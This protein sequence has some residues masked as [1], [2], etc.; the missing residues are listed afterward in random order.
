MEV[1]ERE[2]TPRQSFSAIVGPNGSGKSNTIDALLFVFGFKANKM[3][4]GHVSEL[5]HVSEGKEPTSCSVEIHF[6]DIVDLVRR[7]AHCASLT[8]QPGPDAYDI[9]PDSTLIVSRTAYKN[10]SSTYKINNRTATMK[11]VTTLLKGRGIDL[12]HKRF[13]ILQGE[14]E[15]IAQMKPKAPNEHEDGL[16][17]YLEDIIGTTRLVAPIGEAGKA[18]EALV[19]ERS[20]KFARLKIV[21]REKLALEP[22]KA[23]A[24]AWIRDTNDAVLRNSELWQLNRHNHNRTL[25]NAQAE[26]A[27]AQAQLAQETQEQAETRAQVAEAQTAVKETM[28]EVKVREVSPIRSPDR[29]QNIELAASKVIKILTDFETKEATLQEREK[30]ASVKHKKLGESIRTDKHSLSTA[31]AEL[32]NS[33]V[34]ADKYRNELRSL[35]RDLEKHEAELE[36]I[37]DSLKGKTDHLQVQVEQ[38]QRDL[39]PWQAK[40]DDKRAALDVAVSERE[41]LE[42]KA[43]SAQRALDQ[44]Q[45]ALQRAR[46]DAEGR[47]SEIAALTDE[48]AQADRN[49]AAAQAK[50][51]A[52]AAQDATLRA[53]SMA[54]R[55]KHEEARANQSARTSKGKVLQE[56]TRLRDQG[57]LDGFIGRLG[58]LGRIDDK[59]DVAVSTACGAL[60]NLLCDRVTTGQACLDHLRRTK[61]G[62]ATIMCLDQLKV[63]EQ[64]LALRQYPE[65]VPRLFDL[66][67]PKEPH[68]AAAFYQAMRDT[69]VATDL[70]QANRIAFGGQRRYRVVTLDGQ[71]IDTSGTMSGG[72]TRVARGIMS[73][74]IQSDVDSSPEAVARF[75]RARIDADEALQ[76]ALREREAA[77][78]ELK[79]LRRRIPEL[80]NQLERAQLGA[81]QD[82]K[83]VADAERRVAELRAQSKPD[84][85]DVR[86]IADLGRTIDTLTT[87]LEALTASASEIEA[88]I[89]VLKKKILDLGGLPVR[90]QFALPPY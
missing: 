31:E 4:Q 83:R 40:I 62:R 74:K 29:R 59:Y 44:A 46:S 7:P 55:A 54:A 60:D 87:E 45:E 43:A 17:E 51:Q 28:A 8:A 71:L 12:D 33:T 73:S 14:V 67:T 86:Q 75:E 57:R 85:A 13:L 36:Q 49:V 10:N 69:L 47:S 18:L 48:R 53:Q 63:N 76:G 88:E 37:T 52:A 32:R 42:Q 77:E 56:L 39:Q 80:E 15:S 35:E 41:L 34:A 38:H 23:E 16:L 65:G 79:A 30:Q 89:K 19:E 22:R 58:S 81:R 3:R 82:G 84:S 72:G 6:R 64:D 20:E 11:D 26:A 50:V 1:V 21:E 25:V 27:A 66:V 70:A 90:P 5:I 9:V 2:L 68:Y 78:T 61:A 24:D